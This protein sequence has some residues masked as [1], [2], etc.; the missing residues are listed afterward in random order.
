MI[1]TLLGVS[2]IVF[3]LVQVIP[4]GPVETYLSQLKFGAGGGGA[5][6]ADTE[7]SAELI[8]NLNKHYGYDKPPVQRYF[9]W[10][11]KVLK[12]DLGESYEYQEPV[13][14]LLKSKLPV[15]L[16][17][18]L[19]SLVL[20]YLISIPLGILKAMKDGSKFDAMSSMSLFV[21]Y[22]I[23][24]Y[25]LGTIFIVFFCG[26]SYFQWFPLQG[27]VSDNFEELNFGAQIIDYLHHITL[28][29]ICYVASQFALT[30]MMMKN[31]FIEQVKQDYVRTAR[32]KGVPK[33]VITFKHV[34][35]NSILPIATEV[36]Y[37]PALFLS[38]SI[39]IEQIFG[40][41]GIGLLNYESIIGR[42]YPVVLGI[43]MLASLATVLG[44]LLSDILYVLIDPRIDYK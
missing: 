31:S 44:V 32:A 24:G 12:G 7:V 18:G 26:G 25:A 29:L 37:F 34:L 10:I 38:G 43:I 22:S 42:D 6:S 2:V 19:F 28:P 33:N 11:G 41:D 35:R 20:V 15:S 14:N 4:G 9:F 39:L 21:S 27:L 23:P 40:L 5:G 1:P 36:R 8:E 13:S 30:T 3:S 16:T 17:F